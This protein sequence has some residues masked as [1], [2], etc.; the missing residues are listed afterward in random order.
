M[1]LDKFKDQDFF[2]KSRCYQRGKCW[3]IRLPNIGLTFRVLRKGPKPYSGYYYAELVTSNKD[4][5]KTICFARELNCH[6]DKEAL[7]RARE[8]IIDRLDKSIEDLEEVNFYE[9][10]DVQQSDQ[11]SN[12]MGEGARDQT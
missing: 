10:S 11:N 7:E 9:N 3:F 12:G 5:S 1:R 8:V 4:G 6:D 2:M